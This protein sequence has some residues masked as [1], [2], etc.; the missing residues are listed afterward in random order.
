[1]L[2]LSPSLLRQP[3]PLT[4]CGQT[5]AQPIATLTSADPPDSADSVS[6]TSIAGIAVGISAFLFILA[7][8][9]F[10]FIH[11]R[12]SRARARPEDPETPYAVETPLVQVPAPV[13]VSETGGQRVYPTLGTCRGRGAELGL[14]RRWLTTDVRTIDPYKQPEYLRQLER[15]RAAGEKWR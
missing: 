7:A 15:E 6:P 5:H 10:W 9:V 4:D 1:M 12:R 3:L 2:P 13:A 14:G 11:P 8:A